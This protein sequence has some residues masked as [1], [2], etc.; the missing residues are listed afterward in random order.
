MSLDLESRQLFQFFNT[1][2]DVAP[3]DFGRANQAKAFAAE[4]RND[5]AINH[6]A[7]NVIIDRAFGSGEIAHHTAHE[8]VARAG[9][10]NDVMKRVGRANENSFRTREERAVRPFLNDD[11]FGTE[12]MNLFERRENIVLFRQLMRFTVIQDKTIQALDQLYQ[13]RQ[14]DVQP[15]IHCV[16]GNEL[17]SLHLIEHVALQ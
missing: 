10:V 2:V 11:V 16:R 12:L 13:I 8:R 9:G 17:R 3:F 7:A 15:Q 1:P 5:A 14:G 4:R 6:R